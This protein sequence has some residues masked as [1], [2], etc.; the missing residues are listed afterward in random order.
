[1]LNRAWCAGRVHRRSV[2]L[3][4]TVALLT[5]LLTV[6]TPPGIAFAAGTVLFQNSFTNRTVDGTGTVT[7]PTPT[8]GTN[9]ACLTATGN[10]ATLPLLS[11]SATGDAQG[12]GKLRLTDST[13]N[14]VGGVYGATSFPTSNG[15]DVTFNSYQWGGGS[16]DGI[17]FVLAA[18]DPANSV[19]PTT[20]GPSGGSLGYSPAGSVSGLPNAYL[21]VGLDVFGNFSGT[22]FQGT[23]C[24][25]APNIAAQAAGSV[26]VRGPGNIRVGYCGLTTTSDG[27]VA[28]K[29][30][31]RA[32]TRAAS[33]VPVQVLIN[34]TVSA[35]TSDSGVSVAAGTYKVV[36]T[37]V[38]GA[39][40]T[41]TGTLPTVPVNL[42][43][44]TTWTSNG[45]PRQLAFGFIGSTGSV[46]DAH[47][48]SNVKVLTFNPV[49][50]LAVNTTSFSAATSAKGDPVSYVVT[51]SVLAGANESVPISV[52]HTVPAGVVPVGAYGTGWVC[53]APVGIKVTC[54]T[55]GSSFTNG[56]TLPVINVVAIVTT[57]GVTSATIQNSSVTAVSSVDANPATD[58]VM[59]AGTTPAA[60]TSVFINPTSGVSTGG[61]VVTMQAS[62][63]N[64]TPTAIEIGT[65]AEQQAG[66]SVVLL[67]CPSG[68]AVGCF[69]NEG[70]TLYI[71]SMPAR[72][73]AAVVTVTV[74][75]LGVAT[76]AA[77]TYTDR[78]S[79]PATPTDAAGLLSA[80]VSW[81]APAD[82]GSAITRY[83][84]TPYLNNVAQTALSFDPAATTRTING[85]TAGGSYRFTVA[86]VNAVGTSSASGQSLAVTPYAVA[87]AP[88]I[89]AVVAGDLS[90]TLTWTAPTSNGGAPITGYV[91][92]PVH[93][94][95]CPD[96][97]DLCRIRD[98]AVSN[99]PNSWNCLYFYRCCPGSVRHVCAVPDQCR[100]ARRH[101][102]RWR[103]ELGRRQHRRQ[104]AAGQPNPLQL[105]QPVCDVRCHRAGRHPGS[106]LRHG[107]LP[108]VGNAVASSGDCRLQHQSAAVLR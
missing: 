2:A 78:P 55:S 6:V 103:A 29:L 30:T 99:G 90:A 106:H 4:V 1:M 11:C 46:T 48:I 56:T 83:L 85:L 25:N 24:T 52:S 33:V 76:A 104:R 68:R 49:P 100:R 50:Q 58:I 16:A 107:P 62:T 12:S 22:G 101:C 65:V 108:P 69:N 10:S 70:T 88:T 32:A 102:H 94:D 41:L 66:T 87:S 67:P 72:A 45:V 79:A 8:S 27:T 28:S 53:S 21:G 17:A 54:T 20:I 96:S 13:A 23:G 37:P 60:P 98:N 39:T 7:K 40:K 36:V 15:L 73:T 75:T 26:V 93:R 81:V 89:T 97:A 14:L 71:Q 42:Y 64:I 74:V 91:V 86:A 61:G 35:F 5:T 19:A 3:I 80:T 38:G 84:I 95:N 9:V 77:Y 82:N 34:P 59:A 18:V 31:L 43:P 57:A 51:P 63:S 92:T 47:E 105:E 44:S